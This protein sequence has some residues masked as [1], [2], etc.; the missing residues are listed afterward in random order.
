[1]DPKTLSVNTRVRAVTCVC[2]IYV[3]SIRRAHNDA[4]PINGSP[5]ALTRCSFSS[6]HSIIVKTVLVGEYETSPS[7][8]HL[9]VYIHIRTYIRAPLE[10]RGSM[11]KLIKGGRK[12]KETSRD[13]GDSE[14]HL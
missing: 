1:M 11:D 10:P 7:C 9:Y 6:G 13:A 14:D 4:I 12:K 5:L 2:I 3:S 8:C